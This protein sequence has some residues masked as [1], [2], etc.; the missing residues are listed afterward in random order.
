MVLI[1]MHGEHLSRLRALARLVKADD[2]G[3]VVADALRLYETVVRECE[4]GSCYFVQR[5]GDTT[6]QPAD[7][8]ELN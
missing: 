7:F 6:P 4:M 3:Q 2:L 8:F 1:K 5:Q